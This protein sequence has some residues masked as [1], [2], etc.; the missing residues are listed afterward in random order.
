MGESTANGAEWI[1]AETIKSKSLS[2]KYAGEVGCKVVPHG[3]NILHQKVLIIEYEDGRPVGQSEKW[4][5]VKII[6]MYEP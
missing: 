1:P 6:G 4:E 3:Q 5:P 2:K